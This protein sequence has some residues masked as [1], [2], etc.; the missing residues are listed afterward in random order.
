MSLCFG[1]APLGGIY[2]S[3]G[4]A[5]ADVMRHAGLGPILRWVDDHLF[6]QIPRSTLTQYNKLRADTAR[7]INSPIS[8]S[9]NGGRSFF[10]GSTLPDGWIEE[11]DEDYSS[12]LRDFSSTSPR[13]LLKLDFCYN[14]DDIDC[15]SSELGIPWEPSKDIP[16]SESPSFL[17]FVWDLSSHTVRLTE[18]KRSKYVSA[19]SNW[20]LRRTHTLDKVQSLLGK[21]IHVSQI[22]PSARPY[23]INLEAMIPTFGD[24]PFMP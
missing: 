3:I 22:Y 19:L 2:R 12:P 20:T 8:I 11:Y 16:F 7:R 24:T 17:G 15:I 18:Y 10:T 23:L 1:F 4:S 14:I 13:P 9:I 6:I 21:L 5:G